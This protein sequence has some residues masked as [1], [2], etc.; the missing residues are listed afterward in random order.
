MMA[1]AVPA[2]KVNRERH[3]GDVVQ[4]DGQWRPIAA[5]AERIIVPSSEAEIFV[6]NVL[7]PEAAGKIAR[8][9]RPCRR[10]AGPKY[11]PRAAG[12]L[13][14]V[15]VRSCAREHWLMREIARQ[16][17]K[18]QPEISITVVGETLNDIDLM[19]SSGAF[20]TG[21]VGPS[22]FG[23]LV[24]TLAVGVPQEGATW[25]LTLNYR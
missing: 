13:G 1:A 3:S 10:P 14:L 25:R 21:A 16:S 8:D 24:A 18:I 17:K 22:D 6:R 11:K 23:H 15:P 12:H 2:S 20:V 9:Y 5:G 19:R 7:P 4:I